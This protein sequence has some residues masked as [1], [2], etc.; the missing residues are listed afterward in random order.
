MFISRVVTTNLFDSS[1]NDHEEM[2]HLC[3]ASR[4]LLHKR[5]ENLYMPLS[6][7]PSSYMPRNSTICE[8][9]ELLIQQNPGVNLDVLTFVLASICSPLHSYQHYKQV[10]EPGCLASIKQCHSLDFIT[11]NLSRFLFSATPEAW[12]VLYSLILSP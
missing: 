6:G 4:S 7:H 2:M 11:L 8:C 5:R 1:K 12:Y 3:F 10:I 9:F